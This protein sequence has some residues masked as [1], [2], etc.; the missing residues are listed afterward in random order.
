L[1]D[2]R[3]ITGATGDHDYPFSPA[4]YEVGYGCFESLPKRPELPPLWSLA[5]SEDVTKR[6]EFL[7]LLELFEGMNPLEPSVID[8]GMT[9]YAG[10]TKMDERTR[11][12]VNGVRGGDKTYD[13]LSGERYVLAVLWLWI[14]GMI[15]RP[16]VRAEIIEERS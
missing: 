16:V 15:A 2:A 14:K 13:I 9:L 6:H 10:R 8:L 7:R 4:M 1:I 12:C 3:L 11:L 5:T